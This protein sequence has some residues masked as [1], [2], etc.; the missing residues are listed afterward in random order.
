MQIR[1]HELRVHQVELWRCRNLVLRCAQV[2]LEASQARYFGLYDQTT[3]VGDITLGE[4][5]YL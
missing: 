4:G 5:A 2:E 3:E 1:S